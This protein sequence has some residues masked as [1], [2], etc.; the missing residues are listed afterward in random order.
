MGWVFFLQKFLLLSH[1]KKI[2]RCLPARFATPSPWNYFPNS[3]IH[4]LLLSS[5]FPTTGRPQLQGDVDSSDATCITRF[6]NTPVSSD[7][8]N[9]QFHQ[10]TSSGFNSSFLLWRSSTKPALGICLGNTSAHNTVL[11]LVTPQLPVEI[12]SFFP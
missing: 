11:Q 5:S 4:S 2:H 12:S 3:H 8:R 10:H 9:Y 6:T 1:L 7:L